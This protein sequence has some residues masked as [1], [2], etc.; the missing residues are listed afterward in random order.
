[1]SVLLSVFKEAFKKAV[2]DCIPV[3]INFD[4]FI[5]TY[6]EDEEDQQVLCYIDYMD[7]RYR[8]NLKYVVR[9]F[10]SAVEQGEPDTV[11][12]SIDLSLIEHGADVR[13]EKKM[14][15][16]NNIGIEFKSNVLSI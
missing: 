2:D 11:V 15:T 14:I 4:T 7:D 12:C 13:I 3:H 10:N 5:R 8:D 1:M 6:H 9:R 16:I